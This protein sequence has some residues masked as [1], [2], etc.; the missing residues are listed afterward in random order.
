MLSVK[1]PEEVLKIIESEFA[2]LPG[3]AEAVPLTAAVGRVLAEDVTAAE[4]VPAFGI[5]F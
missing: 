5:Y 1:T 3:R 2:P 4:F